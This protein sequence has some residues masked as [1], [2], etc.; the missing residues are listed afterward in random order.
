MLRRPPD[1]GHEDKTNKDD[2]RLVPESLIDGAARDETE[3]QAITWARSK[4]L[5]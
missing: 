1:Q 4:M 3:K 2:V 5:F